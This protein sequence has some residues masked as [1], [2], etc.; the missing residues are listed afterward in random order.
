MHRFYLPPE[1]TTGDPLLL[2]D[3]E[4]HHAAHVLR[5]KAGDTVEVLDGVGTQLT[6][7]VV[8]VTRKEMSLT[9]R[10]RTVV[11]RR[12]FDITLLQAIVKGKTMETI[13]QKGTELGV[14]RIVPI[15]TERTV[16]QLDN[17]GAQS[18]QTKWQLLA[19]E[20]IKQCGAAWLPKIDTPITPGAFLKH[21]EK[22]DLSLVGS[23]EG[24]GRH[25]RHWFQSLSAP[26]RHVAVW[27][28]PEGDFTPAELES[29]RASGAKPITLG[30]LVLR[31][32]TAA[33]Y[34]L[35]V[36]RHE[37]EWLSA[38]GSTP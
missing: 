37:L 31:A 35:S 33:I 36:I 20:A 28:G 29:I 32:D 6:C 26:P 14:T 21:G 38:T 8:R 34:S 11:A 7:E 4:A 23:L 1:Q 9:T 12:P 18:K 25:A 17:E 16:S 3:R 2:R 13:I 19:I 22:F 24:D 10:R 30:D 5:L 27:I 15:Q